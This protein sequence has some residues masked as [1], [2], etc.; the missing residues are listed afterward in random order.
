MSRPGH[1]LI[2]GSVFEMPATGVAKAAI[3]LYRACAAANPALRVSVSHQRPLVAEIPPDWARESGPVAEVAARLRPDFVHFPWNG[4]VPRLPRGVR[5]VMTLHDV[6]PL[7]I[8]GYF[9]SRLAMAKYWLA[10][11]RDCKRADLVITDSYYSRHR[12]TSALRI[13]RDPLVVHLAALLPDLMTDTPRD[14]DPFF[15]Y[16][17]GY[18]P[19]KGINVMLSLFLKLRRAG[20]LSSRL[21]FTGSPRYHSESFR[22]DMEEAKRLGWVEERGYLDD[23]ALARCFKQ[24][25][26]LIYPSR[27]EGFGFPPV[28]AMAS[29]CPVLTTPR[30]SL[31]E[32]CADAALYADP[33]EEPEFARLWIALETDDALRA[34]LARR[35]LRQAARFSWDRSA[36]IFLDALERLPARS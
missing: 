28:E 9:P 29:G 24:A 17:G 35:G 34:D 21:V 18:D 30:T 19:R 32:V 20:A 11:R 8:P 23:E 22:R 25:R 33:D 14:A 4:H 3:G 16:V 27:Y 15:L 26:A 13:R 36:R 7:E 1:I 6:L 2:D 31:P 5:A 12:I 10:K